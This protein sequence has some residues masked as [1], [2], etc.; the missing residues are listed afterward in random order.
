MSFPVTRTFNCQ[1]SVMRTVSFACDEGMRSTVFAFSSFMDIIL[2][3]SSTMSLLPYGATSPV[4]SFQSSSMQEV[5]SPPRSI[6]ATR[7]FIYFVFFIVMRVF[8]EFIRDIEESVGAIGIELHWI[9]RELVCTCR[10]RSVGLRCAVVA[11]ALFV[12]SGHDVGIVQDVR[13]GEVD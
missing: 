4:G 13:H 11:S 1:S 8:L 7:N 12:S 3:S 6:A 10:C 2:A 9:L 5:A